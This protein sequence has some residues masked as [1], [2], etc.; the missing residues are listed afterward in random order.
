MKKGNANKDWVQE[1]LSNFQQI[2]A[3]IGLMNKDRRFCA[4]NDGGIRLVPR[5]A[6]REDVLC[7]LYGGRVL[8]VLRPCGKW[9]TLTSECYV[10]SLIDGEAMDIKHLETPELALC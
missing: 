8:F 2:H 6:A 5:S 9:Y 4:T 3:V 1:H 10:H 7:V